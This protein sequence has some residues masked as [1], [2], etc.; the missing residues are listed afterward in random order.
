MPA[1]PRQR[2]QEENSGLSGGIVTDTSLTPDGWAA[3]K[4]L[5]PTRGLCPGLG[6]AEEESAASQQS[7]TDFFFSFPNAKVCAS[8]GV[9]GLTL[10]KPSLFTEAQGA[11]TSPVP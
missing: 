6:W 2:L 1:L 11:L 5:G 10:D 7:L 4:S 8:A 9:T 3:L